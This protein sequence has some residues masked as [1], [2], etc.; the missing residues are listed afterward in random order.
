MVAGSFCLGIALILLLSF[1]LDYDLLEIPSEIV[2]TNLFFVALI[3]LSTLFHFWITA[4]KWRLVTESIAPEADFRGKYFLYT[5]LNHLA[6]QVIPH[7]IS[8]LSV[9]SLSLRFGAQLPLR[10]GALSSVYDLFF[11]LTITV[12]ALFASILAL[13]G[14]LNPIQAIMFFLLELIL[15]GTAISL[16]TKRLVLSFLRIGSRVP[17][18]RGVMKKS[19]LSADSLEEKDLPLLGVQQT[20]R[21]FVLSIIRYGNLVLRTWLVIPASGLALAF[22]PVAFALP[23]I[24]LASIISITPANL[25]ITEW[26]WVGVLIAFSVA[27]AVAVKYALLRRILILFSILLIN[28]GVLIFMLLKRLFGK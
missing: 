1:F 4:L 11:D 18:L 3:A 10:K 14:L 9:R 12:L 23:V 28:A 5:S 7:P 15:C 21:L 27:S 2:R 20:A 8:T 19:M 22:Y 17:M 16:F 13:T 6:A 24:L 25:G 26:T